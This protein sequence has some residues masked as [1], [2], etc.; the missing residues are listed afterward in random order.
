MGQ[1]TPPRPA[2]TTLSARAMAA[3]AVTPH[4]GARTP[5]TRRSGPARGPGLP[6]PG[7]PS[8]AR[9]GSRASSGLACA[10]ARACV[11]RCPTGC[12][13]GMHVVPLLRSDFSHRMF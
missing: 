5:A 12:F 10:A 6:G 11:V 7:P 9:P 3:E 8:E 2:G 4:A 1:G 13:A